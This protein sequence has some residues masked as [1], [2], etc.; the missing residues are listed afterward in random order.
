MIIPL[1]SL[2]SDEMPELREFQHF[3]ISWDIAEF[4]WE[5][6]SSF[7]PDDHTPIARD[8]IVCPLSANLP[9]QK[10]TILLG[11]VV[12]VLQQLPSTIF[13]ALYDFETGLE[14]LGE[15]IPG[16]SPIVREMHHKGLG[17]ES[18]Y[19]MLE[20]VAFILATINEPRIVK[21]TPAGTRQQRRAARS[22][23]GFAI[24]AWTR[25][26]WDLSKPT[27]AKQTRD[28]T[29]HNRPL[30]YRRGHFRRAKDYYKGAVRRPDAFR[31]E[32]RNLWWQWID[33]QWVGHPAFGVKRSV[34]SPYLSGKDIARK[35]P[36][37]KAGA[38]DSAISTLVTVAP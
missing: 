2:I 20:L 12:L 18:C 35:A 3:E 30:H 17:A 23:M 32:D 7:F 8:E 13:V 38:K 34:H 4:A 29:F 1:I 5:Q 27:S 31:I 15:L 36:W 37:L 22:G 33:G 11:Q 14:P 28:G 10:M 26:S 25:V 19:N 24:D 6:I 16:K 9:A 21:L